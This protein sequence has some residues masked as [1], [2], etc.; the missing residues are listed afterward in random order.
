MGIARI[1]VEDRIAPSSFPCSSLISG[2]LWPVLGARRCRRVALVSGR[3]PPCSIISLGE[4][5]RPFSICMS[6]SPSS[7]VRV[8]GLPARA[9]DG[10]IIRRHYITEG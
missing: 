10:D 4:F 9:R 3:C 8:T 7:C 5:L 2:P 1:P 6:A